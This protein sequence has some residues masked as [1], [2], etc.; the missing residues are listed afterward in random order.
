[1]SLSYPTIWKEQICC[2]EQGRKDK[3]WRNNNWRDSCFRA[4]RETST[5]TVPATPNGVLATEVKNN[6]MRWRQP[7]G[8]RT[9]V[10]EDGGKSVKCGLVSSN[11]YPRQ[12]CYRN[13]CLLC[14]QKDDGGETTR[15][16]LN[17]VGYE[18][19]CSRCVE[20]YAY[21]G[22]TSK[23]GYTRINQHWGDYRSAA[24][25]KIPPQPVDTGL[26]TQRSKN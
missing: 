19:E 23:T 6:L 13:D 1:M 18:V 8:T 10:I 7:E 9:K 25:A 3:R 12:S 16:E 24:A 26:G 4:G 5:V 20:K 2:I 17:S 21:I 14:I 15:C 22:E 11:A